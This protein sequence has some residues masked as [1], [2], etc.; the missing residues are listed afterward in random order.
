MNDFL[1]KMIDGGIK[2]FTYEQEN[3]PGC[4]TCDYGSRYIDEFTV[5]LTKFNIKVKVVTEYDHGVS[6]DFLMKFFIRNI[7][8]IKNMTE[9]EL[10]EFINGKK[11]QLAVEKSIDKSFGTFINLYV[12]KVNG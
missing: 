11:F 5:H 12:N 9:E 3:R 8:R 4:L 10:F 6:E 2:D 7:D 1:I